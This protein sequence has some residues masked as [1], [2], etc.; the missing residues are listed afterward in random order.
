MSKQIAQFRYYG[1]NK[2]GRNYPSDISRANLASGSIFSGHLPIVQLGIQ[3]LPGT[4]FYLNN[5][6]DP[7]I[8]GAT[9]I[10]ELDIEGLSTI[11]KIAFDAK[12]ISV[13]EQNDGAYL[14]V[15]IMYEKME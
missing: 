9:G 11:T 5:S 14:L 12:S 15:D 8:I 13:I 1:A 4:K 2:E 7:I 3:A 6:L 10:Y